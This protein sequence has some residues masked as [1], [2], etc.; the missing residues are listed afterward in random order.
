MKI[1]NIDSAPRSV[2]PFGPQH[3]VLPEPI[4]IKL[5]LEDEKIVEATPAIGY[6]HRGLEKLTESKDMYKSIFVLERICGICS[7]MHALCYCQG[8]EELMDIKVPDRARYLRVIWGE[9]HRTHSHLLWLGLF[10]D[11]F[12]FESLFYQAW[13]CREKILDIMEATAGSRIIISTND[14]GGTRRDIDDDM[15][16]H[17]YNT[18]F[19]IDKMLS[20]MEKVFMNDYT[21]LTR[22]VGIGTLTH[23]E[24]YMYGAVGPLGRGS[25]LAQ[26]MRQLGYAAYNEL[27]FEPIVETDG[28]SNA[29]CKVRIREMYQSLRLIRQAIDK[30]PTGEFYVKP[31]SK[32]EG[33]VVSRVEQPRGECLYYIRG[34]GTDVLSR[35]RV[36]TPTFAN[37]PALVAMMPG[38][39]LSDLPILVL[40]I[41]PCISC[42]ER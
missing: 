19:E 30:I 32:P 12:G 37:I 8:L 38:H 15:L 33:E 17:I 29:R 18:T 20:D 35:V 1:N 14:I 24:A 28:D 39:Q 26:D 2:V 6:V 31:K 40:T 23:D 41:D 4:H 9:L 5:V 10:A 11:A 21:V 34:N 16:K 3:P 7:F 42:T 25:G 36:R 13:R 27:D 22:T